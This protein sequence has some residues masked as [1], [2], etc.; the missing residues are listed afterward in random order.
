MKG[1]G[2]EAAPFRF[3]TSGQDLDDHLQ[4]SC[5]SESGGRSLRPLS[6]L[7]TVTTV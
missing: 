1:R 4:L 3:H 5:R 6:L 7:V 2:R